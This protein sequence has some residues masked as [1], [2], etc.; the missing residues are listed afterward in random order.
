MGEENGNRI[1]TY[2]AS[3]WKEWI[4]ATIQSTIGILA[5]GKVLVVVIVL[6]LATVL[7]LTNQ[8]TQQIDNGVAIYLVNPVLTGA[9]F[10]DIVIKVVV[11][12]LGARV[13][14]RW[15]RT[16]NGKTKKE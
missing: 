10:A 8:L 7:V 3:P 5:S 9:Q 13:I 16:R 12:F 14:T 15:I 2:K 1:V 4:P 6:I 11:A